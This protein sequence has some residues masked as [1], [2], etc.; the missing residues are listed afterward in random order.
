MKNDSQHRVVSFDDEPLILVDKDDQEIG[1]ESKAKCHQGDGIL[2]RAFS[3]F[4][5]ND[6]GQILM[7]K[8][9]SQKKL[10]PMF[11]KPVVRA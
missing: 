11:D 1:Y 6:R 10:W 8:R 2:H 5:F 9:S 4:I 3:I 7:Q